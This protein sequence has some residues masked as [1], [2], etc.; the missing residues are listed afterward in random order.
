MGL[1]LTPRATMRSRISFSLGAASSW[2]LF[3]PV[4]GSMRPDQ[5]TSAAAPARGQMMESMLT[6]SIVSLQTATSPPSTF[7]ASSSDK[8]VS[9]SC[10]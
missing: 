3:C 5:S 2:L 1:D 9:G 8:L 6:G 4:A 7:L 10:W